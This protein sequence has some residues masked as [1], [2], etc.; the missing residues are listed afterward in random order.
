LT[1]ETI[2]LFIQRQ[3]FVFLNL[4]YGA[5]ASVVMLLLVILVGVILFAILMMSARVIKSTFGRESYV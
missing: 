3:S 4:G 2:S 1:T 5:A